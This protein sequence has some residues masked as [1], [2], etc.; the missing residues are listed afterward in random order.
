M[1]KGTEEE[2]KQTIYLNPK[3]T[4]RYHYLGLVYFSQED[5]DGAINQWEKILEIE[6]DFPNKYVVLNNLGIVYNKKQMPDK[7]LEYFLQA[8]QLAPEDS[9]II[10]EIE[11]EIYNIY[12]GQLIKN[13]HK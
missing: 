7:A 4:E 5:Y 13:C 9:T 2:F 8:L 6:P 10:E 3:F 11:K 12:R 1:F